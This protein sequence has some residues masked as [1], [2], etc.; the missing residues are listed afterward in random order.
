MI[1]VADTSPLNYLILVE[2]VEVLPR[3]FGTVLIPPAVRRELLHPGAPDR[4]R[5][6]AASLPEWVEIRSARPNPHRPLAEL[7][8]GEREAIELALDV[9]AGLVLVDEWAARQVARALGM[10]VAGTL[11]VLDLAAEHGFIDFVEMATALRAT[12]FRVSDPV[13]QPLIERHRRER[14]PLPPEEPL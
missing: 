4:V 14:P 9:D 2:A 1:V 8:D 6:W 7:H 10:K 5:Q 11:G 3:L 12:S 13:L